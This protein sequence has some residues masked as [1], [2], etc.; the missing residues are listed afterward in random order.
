MLKRTLAVLLFS[1]LASAA[2]ATAQPPSW[3]DLQAS[4][5]LH[6]AKLPPGLSDAQR[7]AQYQHAAIQVGK[8]WLA[9]HGYLFDANPAISAQVTNQGV[10]V[11]YNAGGHSITVIYGPGPIIERPDRDRVDI[12]MTVLL[13]RALEVVDVLQINN[14]Y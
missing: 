14:G 3:S 11:T 7:F 8:Q 13:P 2:A 5:V 10:V 9:E 12:R 1:V 4:S 6:L